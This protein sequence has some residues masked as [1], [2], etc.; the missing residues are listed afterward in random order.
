MRQMKEDRDFAA[1]KSELQ[2]D[3]SYEATELLEKLRG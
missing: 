1:L 2:A 3:A